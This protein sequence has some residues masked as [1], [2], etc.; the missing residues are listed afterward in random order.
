MMNKKSKRSQSNIIVSV[1]LV[2]VGLVAVSIVSVFIIN[3]VRENAIVEN[4]RVELNLNPQMT[5]YAIQENPNIAEGAS[6]AGTFVSVTAGSRNVDLAG[7]AISIGYPDGTF[8][9]CKDS[10]SIPGELETRVYGYITTPN[11]QKPS[12]IEIA[13]IVKINGKE[14][15]LPVVSSSNVAKNLQ[16][17]SEDSN[18]IPLK[19]DYGESYPIGNVPL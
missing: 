9:M 4:A 3:M 6:P 12:K 1:L 17:Q 10:T 18:F 13:P 2:L 16:E 15:V 11:N 5:F 8:L 14:K 7:I 19:C